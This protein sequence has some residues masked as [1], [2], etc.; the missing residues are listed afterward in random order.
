MSFD[1][2]ILDLMSVTGTYY[3]FLSNDGYG[4]PSFSTPVSF[5]CH[6][7]YKRKIIRTD[8]EQDVTS[9]AQIQ[10][11]P[12]GYVINNIATPT[13]TVDDRI[14]LPFDDIQRK[15]LDISTFTD[16]DP[17]ELNHQSLYLE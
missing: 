10:M 6:V 2:A 14:S 4:D 1:P 15:V 8:T 5:Q 7:T 3:P 11:P 12:G 17:S 9:T 16:N 13:V